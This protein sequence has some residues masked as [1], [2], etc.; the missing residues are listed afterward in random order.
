LLD[1]TLKFQVQF[2]DKNNILFVE[3]SLSP[4]CFVYNGSVSHLSLFLEMDYPRKVIILYFFPLAFHIAA[5]QHFKPLWS[6][7]L[8]NDHEPSRALLT[9]CFKSLLMLLV[10]VS[11]KFVS[12]FLLLSISLPLLSTCLIRPVWENLLVGKLPPA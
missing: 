3:F 6:R 2:A 9:L 1:F 5:Q 8:L 10:P 12:E 4:V 7:L 11:E